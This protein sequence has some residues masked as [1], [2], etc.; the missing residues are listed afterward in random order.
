[1]GVRNLSRY[2]AETVPRYTSYPPAPHFDDTVGPE[3]YAG[4]L[5]DLTADEPVSVY[6]HVPYCRAI[7]S[8]CGCFTKATKKPEPLLAYGA[9]LAREVELAGAALRK[10]PK[11]THIHWGGGTPSLLPRAG[12]EAV[13]NA[14]YDGFDLE[15]VEE[16]AI[17]LDPREVTL[18]Q[19]RLLKS[20]GV[21]RVSLGIQ[22][23]NAKV[24]SAIGRVQPLEVVQKAVDALRTAGL[25]AINMDVMY[26][27]PEQSLE[28]VVRSVTVCAAL[29]ANR[30]ALF[31]YAHVPWMKKHQSLI[32]EEALPSAGLRLEQARAAHKA[33]EHLGYT[34]IGFDHFAL[35]S[36]AI[37]Q[38][39]NAGTLRR[40]FQG[41]TTD[42]APVMLGFGASAI[43][44]LPGGYAQNHADIGAWN[45]AIDA[46]SFGTQRGFALSN[47]DRLRGSIIEDILT[48]FE[49]DLSAERFGIQPHQTWINQELIALDELV[50][51][52]LCEIRGSRVHIPLDARFL[53]RIVAH[54][55]DAFAPGSKARHSIAV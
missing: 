51:D 52:G 20:V 35:P 10:R 12:F 26:G 46:G 55:F 37:A 23:L 11:V 44:K 14:L 13:F 32:D 53:A 30:I 18:A 21:T 7:C 27:L 39:Q 34:S 6:L 38:A 43:G 45:R 1:M 8:Y 42:T 33:L 28:D 36:D 22:D 9:R 25:D 3:R 47:Q 5:H 2:T 54:R 49:V 29:G 16:H 40:N 50:E 48:R 15:G 31:G 19:A 4:W 41:Y 17:E 24:Q